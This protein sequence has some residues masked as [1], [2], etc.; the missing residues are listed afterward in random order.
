MLSNNE[1]RD[2]RDRF[3]A[4]AFCSADG[5]LE[6]DKNGKITFAA[7]VVNKLFLGLDERAILGR[8][9]L[10]L[11]IRPHRLH[12]QRFMALVRK[13]DRI[14]EVRAMTREGDDNGTKVVCSFC[15]MESLGDRLFVAVRRAQ[16]GR[17]M[18]PGRDLKSGLF[19]HNRFA[20]ILREKANDGSLNTKDLTVSVV[21]FPYMD[22]MI[23]SLDED[24]QNEFM[25]MMGDMLRVVSVDGDS[26]AD[27]GDGSFCVLH[28]KDTDA[29]LIEDQ[30]KGFIS[31]VDVLDEDKITLSTD[32]MEL[33]EDLG[34]TEELI[35]GVVY[36]LEQIVRK[37]KGERLDLAK[38]FPE[39][40]AQVS[41]RKADLQRVLDTGAFVLAY[42]P[43]IDVKS[44]DMHH[45]EVLV[46]FSDQAADESPFELISFAEQTGMI[47][48]LDRLI[49]QKA[50]SRL[51]STSHSLLPSVAV[52][53]SGATIGED[54]TRKWL[55]ETLDSNLDLRG[56]L[57]FEVTE[58][59]RIKNTKKANALFEEIRSRG[60]PICLDD[61]GAGSSNFEYLSTLTVDVVKFDGPIVRN[62]MK[63]PRGQ[64]FLSALVTFCHSLKMETVAEMIDSR[65][66]LDFIRNC[67]V[68]YAQGYLFG[69]PTTDLR[70]VNRHRKNVM[71][72]EAAPVPKIAM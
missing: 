42:H 9:F 45:F 30:L 1:L 67:G 66:M 17:W 11:F 28:D 24:E 65:E 18:E 68:D 31:D 16:V 63:S 71:P 10:S 20:E 58:S 15:H 44:G 51:R 32:T 26:A 60:F 27:L 34:S 55:L 8:D 37:E 64:A 59:M 4:F 69:K 3:V 22:D 72:C 14:D 54:D 46:R 53:L 47:G 50:V 7:G 36:T 2:Q 62:A 49:L 39:I 52:N 33:S 21:N 43:I 56:R 29:Q 61:F 12:L 23:S 38:S 35:S 70:V 57:L 5:L 6:V 41:K 25:V 48:Q 19:A 40:V 13:C